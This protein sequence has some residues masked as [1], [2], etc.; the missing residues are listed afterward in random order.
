MKD[1]KN[2]AKNYIFNTSYQMLA[3][4]V[5]LITTPYIS[6]VLK[7]DGVGLHSY[8]YS[9]VCYFTLCAILGTATYGNKQIGVLQDVAVERTKKFWDIFMLRFI[10]SSIALIL[11]L[12]YVFLFATNKMMAL[13]QS[14]Y[15]LGVMFDISWFF[16][17]MEDFRRI[18]IRNYIFKFINVVAIF[19]FVRQY[20][21]LWKYTLSLSFLTW[22]G[23]LTLWPYLRKYLVRVSNYKPKPFSDIKV[24]LQ[25]FVPAAALQ[26]YA[27]L[28][29]T[30]I[31]MITGDSTQNGCYEQ[32]EKIVKMCLMLVTALPTVL[33]PKV[34]K[35]YAEKRE[36]DAKQ[37]LYKAYQFVWFLGTPLM[38]GVAGVSEVLVPVFFGEGYAPVVYIL[39]VMSLLFIVMGLNQTSGTQFFIASGRQNEYTKRIIIG[40]LVNVCFNIALIPAI[41][42]MGAAIASVI[43]E[44]VIMLAEFWYISAH[45]CF[46]IKTICKSCKKYI[47]A[48]GIMFIALRLLTM[49]LPTS[50]ITLVTLIFI[51]VA[52]YVVVL[53]IERERIV[54]LG[55]NTVIY[56]VKKIFRRGD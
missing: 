54:M 41:G 48:G 15:I 33:L 14:F 22:I 42:A 1:S 45:K 23:N 47:I 9:I 10:T 7:A 19:T 37:Y 28:D 55:L 39:P 46:S 11:Y 53:L 38:C 52:I 4:I 17:G 40:G 13:I 6:R 50:V 44:I 2:I 24:I 21:D 5:P 30:M 29:K 12:G 43:G 16:Q 8:T 31:G 26:I 27:I 36:E 35:A 49:Q 56:S 32:S 20:S 34:S 25:L 18:A 3:L 51:G